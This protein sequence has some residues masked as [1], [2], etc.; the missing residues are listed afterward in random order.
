M[1]IF[2]IIGMFF[3]ATAAIRAGI[4]LR[5]CVRYVKYMN[6]ALKIR[7][8]VPCVATFRIP[9][10]D[11]AEVQYTFGG[12][13]YCSDVPRKLID[14][15]RSRKHRLWALVTDNPDD[16]ILIPYLLKEVYRMI[17]AEV[18][19]LILCTFNFIFGAFLYAMSIME[20]S[21]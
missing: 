19:L 3:A 1:G 13:Q 8:L 5:S 21:V 2:A 12:S 14:P 20:V 18:A 9:W 4:R 11:V 10:G 17:G 6:K 16:T 7:S 15:E